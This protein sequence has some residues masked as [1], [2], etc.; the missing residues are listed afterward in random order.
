VVKPGG[1]MEVIR[2]YQQKGKIRFIGFSTHGMTPFITE[3]IETGLFD[4]V[5]LHYHV[6]TLGKIIN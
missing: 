6:S 3:A 1:C 5:N 2:E 4:Y